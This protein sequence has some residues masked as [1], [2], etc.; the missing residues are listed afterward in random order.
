MQLAK[1]AADCVSFPSLWIK[2]LVKTNNDKMVT[3]LESSSKA[4]L[5]RDSLKILT[6]MSIY[7]KVTGEEYKLFAKSTWDDEATLT[8]ALLDYEQAATMNV[9]LLNE[10]GWKDSNKIIAQFKQITISSLTSIMAKATTAKASLKPWTDKCG[11]AITAISDWDMQAIKPF[12]VAASIQDDMA[13]LKKCFLASVW[14]IK[15]LTQESVDII[16]GLFNDFLICRPF[17]F[18][19]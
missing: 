19:F 14:G 18:V 5:P 4:L 13:A 12:L 7:K 3:D 11:I 17:G 2:E 10:F 6:S 1:I 16:E 15:Y 9:G 8:E